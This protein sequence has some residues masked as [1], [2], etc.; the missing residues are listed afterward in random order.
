MG[1]KWKSEKM[2]HP[3]NASLCSPFVV[4]FVIF[5]CE[6]SLTPLSFLTGMFLS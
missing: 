3:C 1:G 5:L 2:V 6:L 4:S